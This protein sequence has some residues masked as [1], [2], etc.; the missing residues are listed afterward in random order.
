MR[1]FRPVIKILSAL[2]IMVSLFM[3]LP[4]V[5]LIDGQHTDW[6]AFLISASITFVSGVIGLIV[7]RGEIH[8]LR[9]KQM[10]LLTVMAWFVIGFYGSL[11]LVLC[12]YHLSITDAVFE[13][14]SGITTTGS[15]VLVGLDHMPSDLLLWR[16]LL[17][18][19]GGIGFIGMAVAIL[20]FLRVG[21]MRL[22]STESSEWSD[23]AVPRTGSLAKGLVLVYLGLSTACALGYWLGGMDFFNAVNHAMTTLAT[24]GYSTSDS[25]FGQFHSN[26]LLW[27]ST[28]FMALASMPFF[29][30]LRMAHGQYQ[31]LWSDDQVRFF[32]KF[33]LGV[34]L[35][36]GAHHAWTAHIGF[37]DAF[38]QAAFNITSIVSTC[39][40]ASQDYTQWGAFAIAIF[41]FLTF[42]G[43]CSG[44]T[45]GGLKIFRFQLSMMLLKEQ[46]IRLMHPRAV[47]SRRYNRRIIGDDIIA[48][49]VAFSF[50]YLATMAA[51]TLLMALEGVDLV[52]GITGSA[53]AL[54]N[55]GPGLGTII[56]PAGNFQ[57]LPAGAK[58]VLS[59]GM[60][61]GRLE[62]L[63]V[64]VVLSPG[65]WRK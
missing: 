40:Y 45:A 14:V 38:S 20:P 64:L 32:V 63:S 44:S 6:R 16:S 30:F 62:L 55:A 50:I 65:F 51:M 23:K 17:Q 57:S 4:I 28:V 9:Q 19:M 18:W 24:G 39:G 52:T 13:S 43:G 53:T 5:T 22:F 29:L 12:S 21:G 33:L 48:S 58:W 46:V 54:A 7:G 35:I 41:F 37:W 36:L 59:I 61:L 1:T 2:L 56:G 3:L 10:F 31:A 47:F 26:T 25:S 34:S 15:T 27:I 11:P 42:V 60:I 49:S 8:H